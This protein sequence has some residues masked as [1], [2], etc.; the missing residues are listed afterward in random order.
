MTKTELLREKSHIKEALVRDVKVT[1]YP[2]VKHPSPAL[3]KIFG[4]IDNLGD[5]WLK[6]SNYVMTLEA[7]ISELEGEQK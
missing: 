4:E 7:R 1:L 6:L 5:A 3:E 2:D